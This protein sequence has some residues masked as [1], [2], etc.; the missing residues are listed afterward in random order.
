MN[1]PRRSSSQDD[2][3]GK[4]VSLKKPRS[5]SRKQKPPSPNKRQHRNPRPSAASLPAQTSQIIEQPPKRSGSVPKSSKR[6]HRRS[7]SENDVIVTEE[8]EEIDDVLVI[9][10]LDPFLLEELKA[11][12]DGDMCEL[13][14]RLLVENHLINKSIIAS[15]PNHVVL[16]SAASNGFKPCN[17]GKLKKWLEE[18]SSD[19][20]MEVVQGNTER[21]G[22]SRKSQRHT[23]TG[24]SL[25][26]VLAKEGTTR[27]N[28]S[29]HSQ[30]RTMVEHV[31][32]RFRSEF[33]QEIIGILDDCMVEEED[34]LSYVGETVLENAI[35]S[36]RLTIRQINKLSDWIN[37]VKRKG[38]KENKR[39]IASNGKVLNDKLDEAISTACK[40]PNP[41]DVERAK[42][43]AALTMFEISEKRRHFKGLRQDQEDWFIGTRF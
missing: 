43:S 17:L 8:G 34:D 13:L 37:V 4:K 26:S 6:E 27:S 12:F 40:S 7:S 1:R 23:H 31:K 19:I 30:N 38:G 5:V 14:S 25:D 20:E 28:G 35:A 24:G 9:E 2:T 39:S 22:I 42:S 16:L 18:I 33:V 29:S 36:G 21:G 11:M 15:T 10:K 32:R 3:V 41:S